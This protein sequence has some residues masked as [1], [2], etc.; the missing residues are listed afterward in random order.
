VGLHTYFST[1]KVTV[2][3]KMTVTF[4]SGWSD[5]YHPLNGETDGLM[6]VGF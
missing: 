2:T 4:L 5:A 3:L 1:T 6:T